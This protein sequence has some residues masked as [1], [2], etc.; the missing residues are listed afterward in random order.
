MHFV[1]SVKM[2][3]MMI[4]V[5]SEQSR[6]QFYM[7]TECCNHCAAAAALLLCCC[8]LLLFAIVCR[9]AKCV[10]GLLNLVPAFYFS[11]FNRDLFL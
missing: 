3:R 7:R 1:A 2:C 10:A 8:L 9:M 4:E 5:S 11:S 6:S